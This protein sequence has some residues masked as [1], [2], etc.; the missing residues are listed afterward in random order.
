M[1]APSPASWG[2]KIVTGQTAVD[3]EVE[4]L[5]PSSLPEFT[6]AEAFVRQWQAIGFSSAGHPMLF[7]RGHL[8]ENGVGTCASLQFS[9][10]GKTLALA[11]LIVRPHRPPTAGGTVFFT[12]EDETGLAQIIVQPD[13]YQRIG[14]DI[15]GHAALVVS[16]KAEKRGSGVNL[17]VDQVAALA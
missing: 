6:S 1:G 10:A 9:R 2:R 14:A 5:L 16:G 11:G 15:Y 17:L 13:V 8:A 7:H 12:L 3:L 4:P